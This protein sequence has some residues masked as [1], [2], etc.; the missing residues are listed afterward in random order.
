MVSMKTQSDRTLFFDLLPLDLGEIMGFKTRFL[1]YTVPG[2]VFYNATRKLVLKGADAI[3]FVADSQVGKMDEN[4]E[5]LQNLRQN[6]SD[7]NLRLEEI[8]WVLQYNKRDLPN[9]YS[10]EELNA[11]LN[12]GGQVP[13]FEAV[14]CNGT[15]VFETFRGISHL[16]MQ[17]VT[18]ELHRSP[19]G[20]APARAARAAAPEPPPAPPRPVERPMEPP[21]VL[22][23]NREIDFSR[24]SMAQ[25]APQ[26][27]HPELSYGRDPL[28]SPAGFERMG[29]PGGF[30]PSRE[31]P[32]R[33]MPSR[34]MPSR[35][36]PSREMPGSMREIPRE[37]PPQPRES[38]SL[39]F[40]IDRGTPGPPQ[41]PARSP[42]VE[43]PERPA[44]PPPPARASSTSDEVLFA[45]AP[46]GL[47][48][49]PPPAPERSS[50][51]QRKFEE[52]TLALGDTPPHA[53]RAPMGEAALDRTNEV[54]IPV[55]VPAGE[56][57]EIVLRITIRAAR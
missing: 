7:Y 49:G 17:K 56:S 15:G 14:A 3:V 31:M 5:S 18:R 40:E 24:P 36:M 57:R 12:P 4:I 41:P 55:T 9:V 52:R 33:D 42:R 51:G 48:G 30:T 16:L 54:V 28:S 38:P 25:Q 19:Q 45:D 34:E 29:A 44:P 8:P 10:V 2:Q 53:G 20:A 46:A 39:A 27:P 13:V 43:R 32:S 35:D 37:A 11:S 22:E 50:G 47:R 23:G 1:L 21:R 26:P 6:L